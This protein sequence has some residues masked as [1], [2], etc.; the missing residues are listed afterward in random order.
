MA[1]WREQGRLLEAP[2]DPG[3]SRH[4][5]YLQ[6]KVTTEDAIAYLGEKQQSPDGCRLT[7]QFAEGTTPELTERKWVD[8]VRLEFHEARDALIRT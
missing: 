6:L 4:G 8:I 5:D 1:G 3:V 7:L 2:A